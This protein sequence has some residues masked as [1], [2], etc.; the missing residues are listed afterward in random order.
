MLSYDVSYVL[1]SVFRRHSNNGTPH[2]SHTPHTFTAN[3]YRLMRCTWHKQ[4]N[5]AKQLVRNYANGTSLVAFG[6]LWMFNDIMCNEW[7][8]MHKLDE[9]KCT[10]KCHY[11]R[12]YSI[13]HHSMAC[14]K[15]SYLLAPKIVGQVNAHLHA[16]F[17]IYPPVRLHHF[18]SKPIRVVVQ[19]IRL[20]RFVR[21]ISMQRD[22]YNVSVP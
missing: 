15:H 3:A 12:K 7:S 2:T 5:N 22:V 16:H 9:R 21:A 17:C 14:D 1:P 8:D 19:T 10:E 13:K 11:S 18:T 20:P 6:L 4:H